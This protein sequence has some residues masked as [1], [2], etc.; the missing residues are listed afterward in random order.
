M[1]NDYDLNMIATQDVLLDLQNYQQ[2]PT[3]TEPFSTTEE[4]E[5]P[6]TPESCAIP[7]PFSEPTDPNFDNVL[8]APKLKKRGRPKGSYSTFIRLPKKKSKIYK[9]TPFFKKSLSDR[10]L[11]ILVYFVS[12]NDC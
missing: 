12:D 10:D 1:P 5:P 2:T 3:N 9:P 6:T 11:Q 7:E 4:P 8:L